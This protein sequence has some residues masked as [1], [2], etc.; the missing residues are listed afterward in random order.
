VKEILRAHGCHFNRL[1]KGDHEIGYSPVK[2]RRFP[3]DGRILSRHTANAV[4][5]QAGL[6]KAILTCGICNDPAATVKNALYIRPAARASSKLGAQLGWGGA[7]GFVLDQ[8]LHDVT[9]VL[10]Q[11]AHSSLW[12]RLHKCQTLSPEIRTTEIASR[13]SEPTTCR[14]IKELNEFCGKAVEIHRNS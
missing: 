12:A 5:K 13:K 9:A 2:Q 8:S 10:S 7:F 14:Q 3:V 4:L 11:S 6:A 1:R